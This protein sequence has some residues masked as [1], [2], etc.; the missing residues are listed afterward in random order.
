MAIFGS[1]LLVL[2][3]GIWLTRRGRPLHPGLLAAHKILAVVVLVLAAVGAGRAFKSSMDM[4]RL[5][6]WVTTGMSALL[7]LGTGAWLSQK[8]GATWLL[9]V[10]RAGTALLLA[11]LTLLSGTINN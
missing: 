7:L 8:Q 5:V 1:L 2:V 6:A 11:S 10:H 3:S 4:L 9:W